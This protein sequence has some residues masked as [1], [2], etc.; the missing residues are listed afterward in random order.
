MGV[1]VFTAAVHIKDG[2]DQVKLALAKTSSRQHLEHV[3]CT[4]GTRWAVDKADVRF[5]SVQ[6]T[7]HLRSLGTV[8]KEQAA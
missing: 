2:H 4:Q 5:K 8:P 3:V 6:K 1:R 7:A